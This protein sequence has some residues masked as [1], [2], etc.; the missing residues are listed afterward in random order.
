MQIK[1]ITLSETVPKAFQLMYANFAK[2]LAQYF[3]NA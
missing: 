3:L 2:K 1:Q